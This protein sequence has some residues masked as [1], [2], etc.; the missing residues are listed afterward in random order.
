M[1]ETFKTELHYKNYCYKIIRAKIMES[2]V[3]NPHVVLDYD[4]LNRVIKRVWESDYLELKICFIRALGRIELKTVS[5]PVKDFRHQVDHLLD[6]YG[7]D[8]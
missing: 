1:R 5:H 7:G 8:N 2:K 4:R 6:I 3:L